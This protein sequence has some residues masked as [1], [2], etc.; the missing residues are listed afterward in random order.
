VTHSAPHTLALAEAFLASLHEAGLAGHETGLAF[1]LIYDYKLGFALSS[2]DS[3]NEQRVRDPATRR[4]L[5]AFLRS[6]PADRFPTLAGLGESVW[7]DN[8]DERFT[9]SLNTI[10]D[11]LETARRRHRR[12]KTA[13]PLTIAGQPRAG[14]R[15]PREP[16]HT[17]GDPEPADLNRRRA[18]SRPTASGKEAR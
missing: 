10:I 6:L 17:K 4:R 15:R 7:T 1:S 12:S 3:V 14:A 13:P 2:P 11:G 16:R 8:S 5:H 9:A 18:A